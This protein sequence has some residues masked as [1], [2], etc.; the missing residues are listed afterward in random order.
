MPEVLVVIHNRGELRRVSEAL[1]K[2]GYAVVTAADGLAGFQQFSELH[3][4]AVIIDILIPKLSGGELCKKIRADAYGTHVPLLIISGLFKKID[5]ARTALENWRADRYFPAPVELSALL[6]ALHELVTDQT[7]TAPPTPPSP[8]KPAAPK[9]GGPPS[10]SETKQK[11]A[12]DLD[13]LIEETIQE[14]SKAELI[15]RS[16]KVAKIEEDL[17]LD[18][19]L[20]HLFEGQTGASAATYD[21]LFGKTVDLALNP[22]V[23]E[24]GTAVPPSE[25]EDSSAS[26]D[27]EEIPQEGLLAEISVPE[28]FAHY[29]H[30]KKTGVLELNHQGVF[31]HVYFFEG[32]AVYIESEG[33]QESLGQILQRQGIITQHDLML[34]LEN[35]ALKGTRQGEALVELGVLNPMQLFQ[36]LRLQT[37]EKLLSLFSWFEG[38]FYFDEQSFDIN[39]IP[40]FEIPMFSLIY[41]GIVN[42][43]GAEIVREMFQDVQDQVVTRSEISPVEHEAASL[44]KDFW[45]VYKLIDGKRSIKNI[46]HDSPLG[47]V[48]TYPILYAML[49]LGLYDRGREEEAEKAPAP[50]KAPATAKAKADEETI[51]EA[52]TLEIEAEP[53]PELVPIDEKPTA[54]AVEIKKAPQPS[55]G[56]RERPKEAPKTTALEEELKAFEE[57]ETPEAKPPEVDEKLAGEIVNL[58]LKIDAI[59][60]YEL[61]GVARDAD[62]AEIRAKYHTLLKKFHEDK[63]GHALTPELKNQA[64]AVVQAITT[65]Y[66]TLSNQQKR[67]DYDRRFSPEGEELKERRITTILAAERAFNQGMLALRRSDFTL[68]EKNFAEACE[69]FPE[70]GEYHAYLGWAKWNNHKLPEQ[71]RA[72]QAKET[73]ERSIK[74][75]PKGDKAYFF[76]GKILLHFGS[77]DK[78]AQMFALAF[79]YN[80]NNDDAKAELRKLQL[81]KEKARNEMEAAKEKEGLGDLLAKDVNL[82]KVSK[83]IKKLFW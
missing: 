13:Q 66:E 7:S 35:M 30:A 38:D 51:E 62:A 54:P 50:T 64:N 4:R 31:R 12:K 24:A 80:K 37:R 69:L 45:T 5:M 28:L 43:Y 53:E 26:E 33:R 68:A 19:E 34:S 73:I 71:Q 27:E 72:L 48:K 21:D 32:H 20:S 17:D 83:A 18:Q 81:E 61:L 60:K 16:P 76:L 77:K 75:N 82:K 29:Y 1:A 74:I 59:N 23:A 58:Y 36:A 47:A 2:A 22:T 6:E 25:I 44:P 67:R 55:I 63:I 39:N 8:T 78:A 11:V 65:A 70:E 14:L 57:E 15:D 10:T 46:I 52:F 42:Q 41:E 79:R 3:P 56:G 9:T 40:T 49:I